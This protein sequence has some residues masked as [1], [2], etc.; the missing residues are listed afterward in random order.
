MTSRTWWE[1]TLAAGPE[2]VML[3]LTLLL[4]S[5]FFLAVF[6]NELYHW[7]EKMGT[8]FLPAVCLYMFAGGFLWMLGWI[9]EKLS[10]QS[11]GMAF[12][13]GGSL[14]LTTGWLALLLGAIATQGGD[15]TTWAIALA[16]A[17][18]WGLRALAVQHIQTS[19]EKIQEVID[20]TGYGTEGNNYGV[21]D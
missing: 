3:T 17:A 6:D 10:N 4:T 5:Y 13:I 19:A 20:L 18:V 16:L 2:L 11:K 21:D 1:H 7:V 15:W 8:L 12:D 14:L 9:K